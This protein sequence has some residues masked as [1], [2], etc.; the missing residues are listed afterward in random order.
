MSDRRTAEKTRMADVKVATTRTLRRD[1]IVILSIKLTIVLLAAFFV[2]SPR[3]RP[4][5]DGNALDRQ[6]LN[7]S[8]R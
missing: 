4:L 2:F 6:I 8:D 7:R 1:I 5:I 3:Q